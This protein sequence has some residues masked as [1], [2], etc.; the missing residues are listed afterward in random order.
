M[1]CDV[2]VLGGFTLIYTLTIDF[3]EKFNIELTEEQKEKWIIRIGF[4]IGIM[5]ALTLP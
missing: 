2:R 1:D 3:C 4:I 5:N